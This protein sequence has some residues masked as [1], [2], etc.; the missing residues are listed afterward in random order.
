MHF[1]ACFQEKAHVRYPTLNPFP[2]A[3]RD[4]G[5]SPFSPFTGKGA[6]G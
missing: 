1:G 5:L 3:E 4:F 6:G 2:Q